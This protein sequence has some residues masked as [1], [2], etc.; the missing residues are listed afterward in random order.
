[1]PQLP[2]TWLVT[3]AATSRRREASLQLITKT[4]ELNEFV[5]VVSSLK[6]SAAIGWRHNLQLQ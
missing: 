6:S 2:S 1:M 4:I 3:N 5:A